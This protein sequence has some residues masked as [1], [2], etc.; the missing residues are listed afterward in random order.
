VKRFESCGGVNVE[1][2]P[3]SKWRQCP[4]L[5]SPCLSVLVTLRVK[6]SHKA[7]CGYR[8]YLYL[9]RFMEDECLGGW[10]RIRVNG[11]EGWVEAVLYSVVQSTCLIPVT[12]N[13]N[14]LYCTVT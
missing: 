6:V 3:M 10:V 9:V 2:V 4:C 11:R 7:Y 8:L 13:S 1:R 5:T 12:G 14:L